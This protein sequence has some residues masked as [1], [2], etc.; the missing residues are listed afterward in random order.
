V[1]V[2]W[3]LEAVSGILAS[4]SG[5]A[6]LVYYATVPTFTFGTCHG[7]PPVCTTGVTTLLQLEGSGAPGFFGI[8]ALLLLGIGVAAIW[9][10]RTRQHRARSVLWGMTAL[11]AI[12]S[13]LLSLD[14]SRPL[15][16]LGVGFALVACVCS[17]GW[18]RTLAA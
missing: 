4:V 15:L 3:W 9:H 7:Q 17:L 2:L 12:F 1:K 8:F 16:L 14:I 10:S 18:R 13:L 6:V 5:G 11:Y